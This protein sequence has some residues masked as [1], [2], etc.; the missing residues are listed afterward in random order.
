MAIIFPTNNINSHGN[1]INVKGSIIQFVDN[2]TTV[3][4]TAGS[5]A[6]VDVMTTSITTSK[7]G[8]KILVEYLCNSRIDFSQG[9]WNLVYHRILCNGTQCMYS[10]HMGSAAL[11]IGYYERTFVYDATANM[12]AQTY[13]FTA[14]C[15]AYQGTAWL[16]T[17]NSGST[18]HYLRLYEIG[19]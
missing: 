4:T 13:T 19:T 18:Q 11:H 3:N 9:N 15:L 16:G 2:T 14:S 7:A 10:G 12:P 6:W 8:N 17:F 1:T 5:G